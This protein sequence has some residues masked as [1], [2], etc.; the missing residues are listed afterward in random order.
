MTSV[1]IRER[2][3]TVETHRLRG[4]TQEKR[5]CEGREAGTGVTQLQDEERMGPAVAGEAR[6][7]GI[8]P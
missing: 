2:R 8:L 3:G 6:V 7:S 4:E 5:S 1:L